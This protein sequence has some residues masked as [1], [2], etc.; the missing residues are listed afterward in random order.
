MLAHFAPIS[1]GRHAEGSAINFLGRAERAQHHGRIEVPAPRIG[2][3]LEP[4]RLTLV[5]RQA[6][7]LEAHQRHQLGILADFVLDDV[8]Q[9][10]FLQMSEIVPQ[11]FKGHFVFFPRIHRFM[12][13]PVGRESISKPQHC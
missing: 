12:P 9:V 11:I 8:Q 1:V 13:P 4:E 10:A 2:D 3:V 5:F 7:K 6:A